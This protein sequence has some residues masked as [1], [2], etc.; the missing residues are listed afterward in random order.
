MPAQPGAAAYPYKFAAFGDLGR[1]SFDD[2]ITWREYGAPAKNASRWLAKETGLLFIHHFGDLSYACGFLQ[3]WDEYLWMVSPFASS[4]VYLPGYGN[5]GW[6][7]AAE[8][9]TVSPQAL[10]CGWAYAEFESL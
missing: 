6:C 1:G 7:R 9:Y 2:G 10:R 5:H 4:N 3:S 8:A